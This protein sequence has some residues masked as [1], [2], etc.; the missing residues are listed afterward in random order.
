MFISFIMRLVCLR[1]AVHVLRIHLEV[2]LSQNSDI[3][4]S[5]NFIAFRKGDF[6]QITT[7]S[8]KLPIFAL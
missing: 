4:I 5:F 1:T 2:K 6:Q 3:G 8:Q 7:K